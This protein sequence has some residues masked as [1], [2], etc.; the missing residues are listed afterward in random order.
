MTSKHVG[1]ASRNLKARSI[2]TALLGNSLRMDHSVQIAMFVNVRSCHAQSAINNL[3]LTKTIL[4]AKKR[5]M[6]AVAV[7]IKESSLEMERK[8][9]KVLNLI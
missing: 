6:V 3:N 7:N 4:I 1:L 8:R 5:M 2:G 9:M